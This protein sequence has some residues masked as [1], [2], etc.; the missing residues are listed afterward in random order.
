[1]L[2]TPVEIVFGVISAALLFAAVWLITRVTEDR[3]VEAATGVAGRW[4]APST[5][6]WAGA[7]LTLAGIMA[8]L[9]IHRVWWVG[10]MF[11]V[12]GIIHVVT[13]RSLLPARKRVASSSVVYLDEHTRQRRDRSRDHHR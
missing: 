13:A 1:M 2:N 3:S 7:L 6:R 9:A 4:I 8:I 5:Y 11:V 10:A 12:L